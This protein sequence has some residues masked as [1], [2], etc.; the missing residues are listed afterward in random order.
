MSSQ[1]TASGGF[2]GVT[3]SAHGEI[4]DAMLDALRGTKGWVRL[5]GILAFIA[6]AFTVVA[7]IAMTVGT[8]MMG[9]RRGVPPAGVMALVGVIYLLGGVIYTFLGLYLVKYS[10]AIGRLMREGRVE[11]MEAA[12]QYQRKFWRLA[13]IMSLVMLALVVLG[14]VAAISIPLFFSR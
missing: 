14:I 9:S 2:T 10:G 8:G 7:A 5:I 12:L 11:A 3:S 4:T 6:A 13:G 1:D